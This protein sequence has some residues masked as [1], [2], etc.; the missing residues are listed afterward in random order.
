MQ[1][2]QLI[3]AEGN[4]CYCHE[5]VKIVNAIARGMAKSEY[6]NN[7]TAIIDTE[8][9]FVHFFPEPEILNLQLSEL[10]HK[11]KE[12]NNLESIADAHCA[13]IKI[14]PFLNGNGRTARFIADL[15]LSALGYMPFM[16]SSINRPWYYSAMRDYLKTGH[17]K[18]MFEFISD[19][20]AKE[21]N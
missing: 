20:A 1:I 17:V 14:H 4:F 10:F 19:C 9:N 15:N 13:F 18:S 6:R 5:A 8:N 2:D 3:T 16:N 12:Q 11:Y 21:Q 7:E